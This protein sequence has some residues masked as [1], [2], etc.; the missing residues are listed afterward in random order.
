MF[1]GYML[2]IISILGVLKET[3][4]LSLIIPILSLGLP[5]TDTAFSIIRRL[6]NK[7]QIFL[8][9]NDHFHHR[10]VR[11]GLGKKKTVYLCYFLT[12]LLST[13]AFLV[14]IL[15]FTIL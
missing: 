8:A 14:S 9:D 13:V 7:K 1:L 2:A 6:R 15:S 5:I 12:F 4:A 11:W 10:L 3:V